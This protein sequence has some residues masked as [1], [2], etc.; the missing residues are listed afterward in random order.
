MSPR[1]RYWTM[2]WLRVARRRTSRKGHLSQ[3]RRRLAAARAQRE[4]HRPAR[5][6]SE[7]GAADRGPLRVQNAQAQSHRGAP[8]RPSHFR[9]AP[10]RR[11]GSVQPLRLRPLRNAAGR[12]RGR[13]TPWAGRSVPGMR[14][15]QRRGYVRSRRARAWPAPSPRRLP[16]LAGGAS[17]AGNL[18]SRLRRGRDDRGQPA[19][20]T[21]FRAKDS[22]LAGGI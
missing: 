20:V 9:A 17:T 6:P 16:K 21:F 2:H 22:R 3:A 4:F 10:Y 1:A 14:L 11:L 15:L 5:S 8:N 7:R 18:P 12:G 13:S 19:R